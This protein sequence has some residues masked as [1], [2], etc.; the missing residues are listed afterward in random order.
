VGLDH[1]LMDPK[2]P[3]MKLNHHLTKVPQNLQMVPNRYLTMNLQNPRAASLSPL[4]A[5]LGHWPV[6]LQHLQVKLIHYLRN[7]AQPLQI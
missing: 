1:L 2:N 7:L 3:Q 5:E 6:G 4:R